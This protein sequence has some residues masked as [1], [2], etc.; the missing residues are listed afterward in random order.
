MKKSP[1]ISY[2]EVITSI[3]LSALLLGP[4][5]QLLSSEVQFY[6]MYRQ[7]YECH[8]QLDFA[9]AWLERDLFQAKEVTVNSSGELVLKNYENQNIRYFLASDPYS[10]ENIWRIPSKTLYRKVGTENSQPLTQFFSQV[11]FT[12]MVYGKYGVV[13]IQLETPRSSRQ[14]EVYYGL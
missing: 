4:W 8:L 7:Q 3:M 10:A 5:V 12:N 6:R 11:H 14:L 9:L 1:G 13:I 2:L